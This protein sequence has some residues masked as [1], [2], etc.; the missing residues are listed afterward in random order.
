MQLAFQFSLQSQWLSATSLPLWASNKCA[1]NKLLVDYLTQMGCVGSCV[2]AVL[3][4]LPDPCPN[5]ER[6]QK[7]DRGITYCSSLS[8]QAPALALS[9]SCQALLILCEDESRYSCSPSRLCFLFTHKQNSTKYVELLALFLDRSPKNQ[10]VHGRLLVY[11]RRVFTPT[12]IS[13]QRR[14]TDCVG[15]VGNKKRNATASS[16]TYFSIL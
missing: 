3:I 7:E 8:W 9:T 13:G 2:P 1:F 12:S 14:T 5:Y 10:K 16:K 11:C 15:W 4:V 6:T